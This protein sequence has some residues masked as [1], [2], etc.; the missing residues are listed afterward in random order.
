MSRVLSIIV[1]TYKAGGSLRTASAIQIKNVLK[2]IALAIETN[3][4]AII[5]A[6]K[7]THDRVIMREI[8]TK[9]GQLFSRTDIIRTQRELAQ[10]GY[11][12]AEKL[13][14]VR[15]SARKRKSRQRCFGGV[16]LPVGR[17]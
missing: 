15:Y 5:K 4:P 13:S 11:F 3:M 2:G 12:N 6:N 10:L 9:P 8:R 16:V 1:K 7:K 14:R 17:M